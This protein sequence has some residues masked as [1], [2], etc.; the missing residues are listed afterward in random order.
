M[1]E[2]RTTLRISFLVWVGVNHWLETQWPICFVVQSSKQSFVYLGDTFQ[3][4]HRIYVVHVL[5]MSGLTSTNNMRTRHAQSLEF[6]IVTSLFIQPDCEISSGLILSQVY[7]LMDQEQCVTSIE[8]KN[9]VSVC[10]SLCVFDDL[11]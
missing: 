3:C 10:L 8:L 1:R 11:V 6:V 4:I 9:N 7:Y 5:M 2:D